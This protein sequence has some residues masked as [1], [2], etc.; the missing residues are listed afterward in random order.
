MDG[1]T[2]FHCENNEHTFYLPSR[3]WKITLYKSENA[4]ETSFDYE[5]RYLLKDNKWEEI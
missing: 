1:N 3:D 5:T 2:V 4:S